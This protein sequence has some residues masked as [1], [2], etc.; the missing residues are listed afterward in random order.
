M[1]AWIVVGGW[2]FAVLVAI[3]LLGFAAYEL[4]WKFRRLQADQQRLDSVIEQLVDTAAALQTAGERAQTL[5]AR[6]NTVS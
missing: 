6:E 5:S 4:S 1:Q 3:V 2:L